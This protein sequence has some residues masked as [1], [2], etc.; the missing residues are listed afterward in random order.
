MNIGMTSRILTLPWKD[1]TG[2]PS[3]LPNFE[4]LA[5]KYRFQ[6]IGK[7]CQKS[8]ISSILLGHH[9]D[10]QAETVLM[11]LAKGARGV[12][13]LGIKPSSPIPECEGIY[14]VHSTLR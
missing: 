10:D 7:Y 3:Q 5:R 1:I 9:A 8:D 14:G 6:A 11:R 2:N 4:S 12:G 13:L